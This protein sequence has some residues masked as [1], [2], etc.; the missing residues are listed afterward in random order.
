MPL[1]EINV[2]LQFNQTGAA[3]TKVGCNR[4]I[5]GLLVRLVISSLHGKQSTHLHPRNKLGASKFDE[6]ALFNFVIK[7]QIGHSNKA[8]DALS[9]SPFNHSCNIKSESETISDGVEVISYTLVCEA[10]DQCL[11]NTKIPED[12][13][14]IHRT[15][16]VQ[17]NL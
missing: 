1:G 13:N 15:Y 11:N 10:V 2:Q 16:V 3:S 9:Y 5:L 8:T 6:L 14:R 4:Q 7:Y 17:C 12:L